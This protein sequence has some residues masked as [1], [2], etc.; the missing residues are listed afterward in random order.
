MT[1]QHYHAS[2][3]EIDL[4]ELFVAIWR[5]KWFVIAMT[6]IFIVSSVFYVM[7]LPNIYKSEAVLIPASGSSGIK[8][9]GQL[10]GL[11]ALAGVNLGA[12]A[13]AD[14]SAIAVEVLQSRNF[15]IYFIEKYNL[16]VPLMAVEGWGLTD[17]ELFINPKVYDKDKQRWL[18][19]VSPPFE[20][21]PSKIEAF[22]AFSK[23]LTVSVDIKTGLIDLSVEHYS[24]YLAQEWA[25]LLIKEINDEMRK[26][27][28]EEAQSSLAYLNKTLA[29]T[30]VADL[31][32]TLFSLIEQQ[33]QT[34]ML[35]N[36]RDE[37]VF[38][39]IDSP[40]VPET[41]DSP[42]RSL[43]VLIA[44]ALGGVLS[45]LLVLVRYFFSKS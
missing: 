9:P 17:N 45:C 20:A 34:L 32:V 38:K 41:K 31:R 27:E 1:N 7:G 36:V 3:D 2:D 14:K 11:A 4:R 19:K 37:Y 18:R 22:N 30:N 42:R 29:E 35:A 40:L 6:F 5:G 24:P 25:S 39:T 10:G 15:L 16:Y 43:I 44:A 21:K 26:R 12:A 13:G 23:L 33:M 8:M 28:L